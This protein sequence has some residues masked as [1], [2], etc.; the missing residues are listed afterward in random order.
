MLDRRQFLEVSTAAAFAGALA[1][2]SPGAERPTRKKL[3]LITTELRS[4]S[5]SQHMGDRF[6]VGY[7]HQGAWH[8]PACDIVSLYVDQKPTGDLSG[9]RAEE[10][11]LKLYPTI[12]QALRNGGEKLAVDGVLLIGEHGD[13]PL[14]EYGQKKYPRYEFFKQIAQVFE[15]DG[16]VAPVFND[17]HLSW[18]FDWAKEMVE[19]AKKMKFPFMAGSSLPVSWRMPAVDL[20]WEAEVEE[21]LCVGFGPVDIYD[22]H[23]LEALQCV[24]ERRRGGETGIAWVQGVR[25]DAVWEIVKNDSG[26]KGGVS[27]KLLQACLSRSQTLA[28]A[29]EGFNHR[30]PTLDEMKS[31]AKKPL[32]YRFEYRDGVKGTLFLLDGLVEDMTVAAQIK[33][34]PKPFSTLVYLPP[35]PNVVYSAALM[36]KV[37]QMFLTGKAAYPVERT[38]LTSGLVSAALQSLGTGGKLL[39]TPHLD[40]RYVAPQESQFA[41]E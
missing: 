6:L 39:K 9:Q 31:L 27:Q 23:N 4:R 24:A 30:Y 21:V 16:Q 13:Y 29:R 7:P 2:S 38:L 41:R 8:K 37:E 34:Q 20:P 36:S 17:K 19:T 1:G 28:Q 25:G 10:F 11:G 5:H 33:N 18:N 15:E 22:F 35:G 26:Q 14:N 32:A 3:A 40:V 12:A